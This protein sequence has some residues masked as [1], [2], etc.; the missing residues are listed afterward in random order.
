MASCRRSSCSSGWVG[1]AGA[2]AGPSNRPI[3]NAMSR[4]PETTVVDRDARVRMFVGSSPIGTEMTYHLSGTVR[5]HTRTSS[6]G[7]LRS[8]WGK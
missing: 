8:G 6:G 2:G 7:V 1:R 5:S 4:L 3:Q